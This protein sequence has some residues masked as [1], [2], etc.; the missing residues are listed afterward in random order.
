MSTFSGRKQLLFGVTMLP[1]V[2]KHLS[3]L[4]DVDGIAKYFLEN[5]AI[6]GY[7]FLVFSTTQRDLNQIEVE[8]LKDIS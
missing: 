7:F 1:A 2:E 3:E 4:A 6:A 5:V 8:V